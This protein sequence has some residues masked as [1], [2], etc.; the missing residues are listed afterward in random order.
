M[1]LARLPTSATNVERSDICGCILTR[2]QSWV[3]N[4]RSGK[5]EEGAV[6]GFRWS[7][8]QDVQS[9]QTCCLSYLGIILG[10]AADLVLE[11]NE[12]TKSHAS[13]RGSLESHNTLGR[14]VGT[15]DNVRT[16]SGCCTA[17]S[18]GASEMLLTGNHHPFATPWRIT[19]ESALRCQELNLCA[20]SV[21][22]EF[23]D[24]FSEV[25]IA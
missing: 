11:S 6:T 14:A 5:T 10:E 23:V 17:S 3:V 24:H 9:R 12:R 13:M 1:E 22:Q 18:C 21:R 19:V 2:R 16:C 20:A 8:D 25:V 7:F 4:R 15:A